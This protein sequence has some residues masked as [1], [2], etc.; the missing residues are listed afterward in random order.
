[1]AIYNGYYLG[2]DMG[3]ASVGWAVTDE[4]YKLLR[5]KGKD[6]WGVRL[7]EEAKTSADRRTHR[8]SRRRRQRERAR[9]GVLREFF[10][11]EIEKVDSGFYQR[12]DDSKYHFEDKK[13]NSKY[14]IFSEKKYSDKDYYREYPTIFHLRKKLIES[15]KPHDVRL[16][17]LAL[18]NMF[19]HRGHFLNVSLS[20]DGGNIGMAE[21]YSSLCD[22]ALD[23]IELVLPKLDD[24]DK[25]ED[26]LSKRDISRSKKAE[27]IATLLGISRRKN[28]KEYEIIKGICGLEVKINTL[29]AENIIDKEQ[30]NKG[31]SFRKYDDEKVVEIT[32]I[33]GDLNF[34]LIESMKQIHDKGLLTNIMKGSDFLSEA[35]VK[36]Y[37]KHKNDLKI[38]KIIIK[39]Y[40]P[41]K[42]ND[43]FCVMRKGN[44]S[45]Y[46]NS[47]NSGIKHR[48]N[49]SE[50]KQEDLYKTIKAVLKDMP[51]DDKD[52]EYVINEINNETF[53]PKQLTASNGIIPNQVHLAEMKVILKNAENY[54]PF[55]KEKDEFN[56]TISEKIIELFKFQ[57]PYYVGPL[58][59]QHK[60]STGNAWVERKERGR[61]FPWNFNEKID[62]K[63]SAEQFIAKMVRHCT[64]IRSEMVLPKQSLLYER[65]RVLNELNNLKIRGEKP[66]VALKQEI[67]N[68]LFSKGK[69]VSRN[70]LHQYLVGKG[71]LLINEIDGISGIDGGFQNT[72]SSMEKF[73]GVFGDEVNNDDIKVIIEKIIFWSTIYSNDKKFLGQRIS[74]AFGD[75]L[76]E[77]NIKRI[78]GFKFNDWGRLSKEFLEM[79]GCDKSTGEKLP[80]ISMMWERNEN[81]MELLSD[82]YT[83]RDELRERSQNAEKILSEIEYKDL[84]DL[85]LSA[86]VKRMVWQTLLILK[87][88]NKV[89][90]HEP[91]RI[92]VEMAREEGEKGKR[93]DSRKKRLLELYKACEKDSRDWIKEITDTDDSKLRTKKLYLY[94]LQK[95]KCMYSG[96]DIDLYE[97]FNDNKYDIDHIYPR[98]YVKDDSLENN[99][100]LVEK[101]FNAHKSDTYPIEESIYRKMQRMW[102]SLLSSDMKDGFITR[103]K[104]NRLINR[105]KF[106]DEQLAGFI[107]RQIVETRQGT[108]A[109]TQI[110]EQALPRTEIVYVKAGNVSDFRAQT[111]LLKSRTVNDFHHA[112]D[113]YL[114]IVV[115][116][117]YYVKFTKNPINFIQEY[118]K[119]PTEYPYHMHQIFY[120][121]VKRGNEMAWIA[122]GKNSEGGSIVT[123]RNMM[124]KNTPLITRMSFE[125]RGGL[126]DQ[127]LYGAEKAKEVGYIPLKTKDERM[128]DV[129]KY[130]GFS[131]VTISYFFL[132]E[133]EKKGKKVRTLE[134]M[135][136]YLEEM[137]CN[138]EDS[139]MS[140]CKHKLILNNP[141]IRLKKIKIQSL[142]RKDGFYLHISGKTGNQ[143]IMRNAVPLCLR[144]KWINYIKK[145]ENINNNAYLDKDI[146]YDLNMELYQMLID[147]HNNSIYAKRPN[148]VGDKIMDGKDKFAELSLID[149]CYVIGQI[150]QLSQLGNY[151]ADLVLIGASKTTGKTQI[152]KDISNFNEFVLIN[153]S[154]TGLYESEIDLLSV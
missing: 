80:F 88:L 142:V 84:D 143:I 91:K 115:G 57:I 17:Y 26:I 128:F 108:K 124:K 134:A 150:I 75:K 148:P 56:L 97:L 76:N 45:A 62:V 154:I 90:G 107:S 42:Y 98:H 116:N 103:E 4:N 51:S 120:H 69:K 125:S 118:R 100:V 119:N 46:V 106:T 131:S 2:I 95:G 102:R 117:T 52:V 138:D 25:L 29:F 141:S 13:T 22:I 40:A 27:N 11:D 127:T 153:Q 7:F 71:V 49:V 145:I 34:E 36:E 68:D 8:I 35:R 53:L 137:L 82:R 47:V 96:R 121:T 61:V 110:L 23:R 86:P 147:K 126:A 111:K 32:G 24:P 41:D 101:E 63:S 144:Q 64:Y 112:Q 70:K 79:P 105:S 59:D 19:K 67:Y 133:H 28:K 38:L 109:V 83:F 122:H 44:Y 72:L 9:I 15:N 65:F 20:A 5:A 146:N 58:N 54:L 31:I 130:G 33:I 6:L 152:S 66:S 132:V 139:L 113:A 73:R 12:L 89:L 140:Y 55:L 18:L 123:I 104:Y 30:G 85:Y 43:M 99:L 50:R 114:N 14:S 87:E 77:D 94:Y 81:L 93:T 48:R 60:G 37:E 21:L 78:L 92:F 74:D 3:T 135:P 129:K 16:V 1:M 149:Q 39:K 10:A 151:G 136:L